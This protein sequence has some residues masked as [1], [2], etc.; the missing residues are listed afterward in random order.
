MTSTSVSTLRAAYDGNTKRTGLILLTIVV[1]LFV[2]VRGA[3]LVGPGWV[4]Q[5][6]AWAAKRTFLIWPVPLAPFGSLVLLGAG[7]YRS[8]QAVHW[9]AA[10]IESK[11]CGKAELKEYEA[12]VEGLNDNPWQNP[13]HCA[14]V[15]CVIYLGGLVVW[16][17]GMTKDIGV[18]IVS[19]VMLMLTLLVYAAPVYI[20]FLSKSVAGQL[21]STSGSS[22][23]ISHIKFAAERRVKQLHLQLAKPMTPPA[24]AL[25]EPQ[26]PVTPNY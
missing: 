20:L 17:T 14:V 24:P 16:D 18:L 12:L 1:I 25:A 23:L 7:L 22:G 5:A 9:Y 21:S 10:I 6:I 13:V 3:T 19:A 4:E 15:M 26:P 8:C 2:L 11:V